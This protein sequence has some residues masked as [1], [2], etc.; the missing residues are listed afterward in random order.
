MDASILD[1]TLRIEHTFRPSA[2][3][4]KYALFSGRV[5][6]LKKIGS[7][8]SQPGQ[9]AI[10]FG[11]RGVG[12]TSLTNVISDIYS[13]ISSE[14]VR[15]ARVNCDS[16]DEFDNIWRKIFRQLYFVAEKRHIG[17][18]QET[19]KIAVDMSQLFPPDVNISPDDIRYA[20]QRIGGQNTVVI[21]EIDR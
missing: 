7:A 18:Q 12:K 10:V 6:Q 17:F 19:E 15:Y 11:E 21:D 8:I 14:S 4:D 2:P 16:G 5:K 1:L 13:E 9:H 20:F 3:I